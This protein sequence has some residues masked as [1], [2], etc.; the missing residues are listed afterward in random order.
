MALRHKKTAAYAAVPMHALWLAEIRK[1]PRKA[2]TLLYDRAGNRSRI[3][4]VCRRKFGA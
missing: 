1:M 3:L 2:V 4:T